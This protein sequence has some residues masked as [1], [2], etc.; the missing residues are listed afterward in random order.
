MATFRVHEDLEKENRLNAPAG[1]KKATVPLGTL[2]PVVAQ[3]GKNQALQ[4]GTL[5]QQQ[6]TAGV[7]V[8]VSSRW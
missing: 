6:R 4:T 3:A 7:S 1:G 8:G 5:L 2:N